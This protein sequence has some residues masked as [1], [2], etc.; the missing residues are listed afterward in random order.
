MNI[1][2]DIIEQKCCILSSQIFISESP[3]ENL[4]IIFS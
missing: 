2:N 4:E 3:S 1:N